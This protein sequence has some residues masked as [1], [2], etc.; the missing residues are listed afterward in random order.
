MHDDLTGLANRRLL[1]RPARR[2]ARPGERS[3]CCCWTS[4]ASRRSTTRSAT[5]SA[6]G[7]CARW[8]TGSRG[9]V[10]RGTLVARLGGDEF[11]VLLPGAD[12]ARGARL[13]GLVRDALAP[14]LR[15]RRPRGGRRGQRR[16]R[17]RGARC[18]PGLGAAVGRPG[19]VRRQGQPG[20]GVEVYRP[21]LDQADSSRLGLLADLRTAVAANALDVHYQPKVDVRT[22]Q[23]LGVEALARWQHPSLGPI[24]PDEFIPLAEQSSLIT[25]L[26]LLVL[27][28]GAAR[29][30]DVA[31]AHV[32]PCLG[33]GQHLAAQPA[34]P[35]ASSTRSA[36]ALAAV[37]VPGVR[38]DPGDHRDQPD[39]RPRR[40]RSP[41]CSGSASSACGSPSTTSAPATRRWPTCS[42]CRSTRSRS[43]GRS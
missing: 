19:D 29:L 38:A 35:R 12:D 2:D 25:P 31:D 7:C 26:T 15:P 18:R 28:H 17:A 27:R 36:R 42:G 33:G 22:G 39:G 37:A 13:R 34:R 41:R 8:P 24:R 14:P 43:T 9:A 30:R 40:V 10:R 4:T 6:T 21:E 5:R 32:G 3:R 11:A 16:R 20:P 23:V 1:G